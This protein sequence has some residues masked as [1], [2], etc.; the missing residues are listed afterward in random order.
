MFE[1]KEQSNVNAEDWPTPTE[2]V[3]EARDGMRRVI[4]SS[5]IKE[6]NMKEEEKVNEEMTIEEMQKIVAE[7]KDAW[8]SFNERI[9]KDKDKKA[10]NADLAFV[11][12]FIADDIKEVVEM[13]GHLMQN[14]QLINKQFNSVMSVIQ[15]SNIQNQ[16]RK[17][18][19]GIQSQSGIILP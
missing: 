6:S 1:Q 18:S 4:N 15:Q 11:S 2:A 3:K 12:N 5:E 9:L 8:E 13:M 16:I 17:G 19:T 10:T 14:Q 7:R